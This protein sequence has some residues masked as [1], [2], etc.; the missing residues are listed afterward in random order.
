MAEKI[1]IH[2]FPVSYEPEAHEGVVY[3]RDNLDPDESKVFFDQ[4]R[5]SSSG[6]YEAYFEDAYDRHFILKYNYSDATYL[7]SRKK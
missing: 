2:N 6:T 1:Y 7:L 4:A 3:L 5:N